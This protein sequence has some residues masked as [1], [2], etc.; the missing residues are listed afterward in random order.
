MATS[1]NGCVLSV[2]LC[3]GP[4]AAWAHTPGAYQLAG[5]HHGVPP[6]VL[7]AIA[8]QE[9]GMSI[10][11]RRVPWPWTLNIA[12][13]SRY[14]ATR[15]QACVALQDAQ[16]RISDKRID[17]G[18]AQLNLGYQRRHYRQP[19]DLLDPYQIGRAHV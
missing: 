19:C 16:R 2:L 6:N 10:R 5:Q 9:S 8:L 13:R 12:G 7:Y 15:A 14:F 4:F 17:V 3:F 1:V 18:L 11:K